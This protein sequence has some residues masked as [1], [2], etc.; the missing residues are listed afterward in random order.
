MIPWFWFIGGLLLMAT[1][2]LLPGLIVIF[3]GLAAVIVACLQWLGF[4]TGASQSFT[5]WIVTSIILLLGLR[6]FMKRW[7][8]AESSF[9]MTDEEV[10]AAGTIVEITGPGRIRYGGTSWP[11]VTRDGNPVEG[12]KA[13]LLYRDNLV[14]VVETYQE[15]EE[16]KQ[17]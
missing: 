16:S 13:R 10:E 12:G 15:L 7:L 6:H 1:E 9:Q 3:F 8:P 5:V 14:W 4:F 11:A 17:K 2:L